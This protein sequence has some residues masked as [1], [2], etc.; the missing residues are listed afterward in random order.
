MR[1]IRR[2]IRIA[3]RFASAGRARSTEKAHYIAGFAQDKWRF[4]KNLTLSLGAAL[5]PRNAFRFLRPT[6]RWSTKYPT[7]SNNIAPR[8]GLTYDMDGG[9]SVVR[10]GYG[11][12]FDKTHFEADRRPLH[13]HAVHQL[14]HGDVPDRRAGSRSAQRPAADRSVPGQRPGDQSRQLLNQLYP[15]GQL[16]RNTGATWDNPD[17]RTPYTDE[18]TVGYERQLLRGSCG[19]RRLRALAGPRHAD[20]AEPQPAAA[21]ESTMSTRRRCMRIGSTTLTQAT[22]ELQAQYPGFVP[23]TANVNQFVNVGEVDYDALMLQLKKRFSHNYSAQVSYTYG[24]SRGNTSGNGAPGSNFQVGRRPAPGAERG[25]DRLRHP[26][27]LHG[28]RHGARSAH[29]D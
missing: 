17:R 15:G 3:S 13:R 1:R 27:Q 6:I 5:R 10:A 18:M 23:F 12:F 21:L 25:P 19:E 11:R 7:D 9:K 28:Q 8:L 14:V 29:R 16:L 2:R 26:P 22:A 24:K 4:N 20:G